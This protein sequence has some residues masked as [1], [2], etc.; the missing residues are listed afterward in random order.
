MELE[1][2][3]PAGGKKNGGFSFSLA[4]QQV[5]KHIRDDE[6]EKIEERIRR[7]QVV[8]GNRLFTDDDIRLKTLNQFL[9]RY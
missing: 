1:N 3:S 9:V 8:H 5:R 6:E 2:L 4:L 7:G